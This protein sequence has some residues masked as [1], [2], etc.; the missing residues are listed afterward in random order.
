M[1]TKASSN[2]VSPRDLA[3][4][5]AYQRRPRGAR[6]LASALAAASLLLI[7]GC[8]GSDDV[9]IQVEDKPPLQWDGGSWDQV[10]W[11]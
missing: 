5:A 8:S 6:L 2:T 4:L 1:N 9:N 3:I 10:R 7:A 11:Q